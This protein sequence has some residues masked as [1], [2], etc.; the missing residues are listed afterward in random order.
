MQFYLGQIHLKTNSCKPT[1]QWG[2]CG[3]DGLCYSAGYIPM[4]METIISDSV[5]LSQMEDKLQWK[6]SIRC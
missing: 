5:S 2:L 1:D 6:G 3:S 4:H